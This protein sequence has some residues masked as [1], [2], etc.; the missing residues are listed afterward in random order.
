MNTTPRDPMSRR[1][2][3][4]PSHIPAAAPP[5]HTQAVARAQD[6]ATILNEVHD[7]SADIHHLRSGNAIVSVFLGLLAYSDGERFWWTSPVL[8][9]FG[10]HLLSAAS[11]PATAAERL[12]AH[13]RILRVRPAASL[14]E[15]ELPLLTD[16]TPAEHVVPR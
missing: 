12:A 7:V 6:L 2:G 3:A 13:Y 10:D 1:G 9:R 11:A 8:D 16:T 14:L 4:A 15:S 5:P